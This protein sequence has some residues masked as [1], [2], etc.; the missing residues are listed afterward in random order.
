MTTSASSGP[1]LP[2]GPSPPPVLPC[3]L[4]I[5]LAF[6]EEEEAEEKE[7]GSGRLGRC[8]RL[9]S[10]S[11]AAPSAW[12][13][14]PP[15]DT[16]SRAAGVSGTRNARTTR[17]PRTAGQRPPLARAP[18]LFWRCLA[19]ALLCFFL[20]L[21]SRS[22]SSSVRMPT[23]DC[24]SLTSARP[25]LR[26]TRSR[27]GER[28]RGKKSGGCDPAQSISGGRAPL[29]Q[30]ALSRERGS[31][32]SQ[33][34]GLVFQSRY[35]WNAGGVCFSWTVRCAVLWCAPRHTHTHTHT[36]CDHTAKQRYL[37]M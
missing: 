23:A 28:E 15:T 12:P 21:A 2:T 35:A 37:K 20:L 16:E 3:L 31:C 6:S 7:T 14:R 30:R 4:G 10:A 26:P 13:A 5:A 22:F 11:P 8:R 32:A 18:T 25:T 34:V 9:T 19:M 1:P 29:A 27:S 17:R 36:L 33:N 24:A